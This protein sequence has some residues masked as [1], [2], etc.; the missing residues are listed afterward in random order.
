[1]RN[2]TRLPG[3]PIE[4]EA[5]EPAPAKSDKSKTAEATV[6]KGELALRLTALSPQLG[7]PATDVLGNLL[8][9]GASHASDGLPQALDVK[10]TWGLP[11]ARVAE[12]GAGESRRKMQMPYG[13][14]LFERLRAARRPELDDLVTSVGLDPKELSGARDEDLVSAISEKLRRVAGHAV[15]NRLRGPHEMSYRQILINVA[16]T[17]E[18][19]RFFWNR[20]KYKLGDPQTGTDEAIED[21]IHK[22]FIE[23]LQ[24]K[25]AKLSPEKLAQVQKQIVEDL[26]ARGMPDQVVSSVATSI[27]TGTIT[28]AVLGPVAAAALFS[29]FW[30][31][32]FGLT[33][34]QLL[35]GGLVVGGPAGLLVGTL[36]FLAGPT[37][38]RTVPTVLRLIVVRKTREAED[39]LAKEP[40]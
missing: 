24:E 27:A 30:T 39:L 20:T 22:R 12:C 25:I 33:L 14:L 36:S 31:W 17:L 1:V 35:A 5:G 9:G 23:I 8:R 21:H 3:D 19:G 13:D 40:T 26:E 15:A 18:P 7:D 37:D 4:I 2:L 16:N 6:G 38:R 10:P 11:W 34:A 32:L 28:G 29:G